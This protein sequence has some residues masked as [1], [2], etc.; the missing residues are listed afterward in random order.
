M[1]TTIKLI[2]IIAIA[3]ASIATIT[4]VSISG[5]YY[6]EYQ[7]NLEYRKNAYQEIEQIDKLE[8]GKGQ[9]VR[10]LIDNVK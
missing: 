2:K 1:F 5:A 3:L 8:V 9:K 6:K 4:V 10:K 7:K